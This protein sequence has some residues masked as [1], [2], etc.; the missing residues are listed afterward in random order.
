MLFCGCAPC[1]PFSKQKKG[2][3]DQD[4]RISLLLE[5]LRFIQFFLPEYVFVEN[6]PGL[7]NVYGKCGPFDTFVT[8]LE[9]SLYKVEFKVISSQDY[10]VPQKRKRLV[11]IASRLGYISFPAPTHGDGRINTRFTTVADKIKH[12][13][14]IEAGEVCSQ[15]SSH[16]AQI[17]CN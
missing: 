1:Q 14:V 11:L 3:N 12:L 4:N 7:Q 5:F 13:P 17:I 2:K 8:A 16:R 10:G 15:D 6:V 9:K